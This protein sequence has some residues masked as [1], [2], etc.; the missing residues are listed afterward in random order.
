MSASDCQRILQ[1]VS[2]YLDNELP[3][4]HCSEIESHMRDCARCQA[5]L[6]SLKKSIQ[7]CREYRPLEPAPPLSP[8]ARRNLLETYR[9]ILANRAQS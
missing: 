3:S 8:E 2:E 4:T 1:F 6:S 9:R 7:L 5:F